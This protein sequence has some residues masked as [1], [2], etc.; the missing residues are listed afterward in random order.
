M[1]APQSLAT[2]A[3]IV[4]FLGVTLYIAGCWVVPLSSAYLM[5]PVAL[6]LWAIETKHFQEVAKIHP[7]K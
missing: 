4:V 3:W 7:R 5:L 1:C 2:L 6:L